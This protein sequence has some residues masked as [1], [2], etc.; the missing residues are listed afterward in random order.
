MKKVIVM[1]CLIVFPTAIPADD[2]V[3]VPWEEIK[4]NF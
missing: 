3:K 4:I 2:S 1:I